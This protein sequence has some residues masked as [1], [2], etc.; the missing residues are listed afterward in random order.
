M[1]IVRDGQISLIAKLT[2]K[3]HN[4]WPVNLQQ[5]EVATVATHYHKILKTY[6]QNAIFGATE[7]IFGEPHR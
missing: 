1:H 2:L 3:K 7:L 6:E 4:R 5:W